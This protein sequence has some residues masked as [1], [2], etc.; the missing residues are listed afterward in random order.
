MTEEE[1]QKRC[2]TAR[3]KTAFAK[4]FPTDTNWITAARAWRKAEEETRVDE[5]LLNVKDKTKA[6]L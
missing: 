3:I 5:C 6:D 1:K 4:A 2:D